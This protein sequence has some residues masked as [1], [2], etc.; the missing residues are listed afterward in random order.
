M[1]KGGSEEIHNHTG[2][3]VKR[4]GGGRS[5]RRKGKE[6]HGEVGYTRTYLRTSLGNLLKGRSDIQKGGPGGGGEKNLTLAWTHNEGKKGGG[7]GRVL[8]EKVM[9]TPGSLGQGSSV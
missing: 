9:F 2:V 5:Q 6:R 1:G 3:S 7:G 4:K 8:G